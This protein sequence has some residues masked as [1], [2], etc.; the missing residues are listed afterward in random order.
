MAIPLSA[1]G[2]DDT[3]EQ[4]VLIH[5]QAALDIGRDGHVT[6]VEFVDKLKVPDAIRQRTR[7]VAGTWAFAPPVK[8]GRAVT[9]RTYADVEACLIPGKDGLDFSIAFS[10]NGPAQF[11]VPPRKPMSLSMPL[12]DLQEQ[13]IKQIEGKVVYVVD[14]GGHAQVETATLN[15][16]ALQQRYG[17]LWK[18]DQREMLRNYRYLPEMVDG[19]AIATRME[20]ELMVGERPP[21]ASLE[22]MRQAS[23]DQSDACRAVRGEDHKRVAI[24]SPFRHVG[25]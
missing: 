15:D 25:G 5:M 22:A 6:G 4:P 24:D 14:A 7:D 17:S 21:T 10:G 8:D 18:R 12:E 13:G 1:L 20:T 3:G 2:A 11:V 19:V 9:G 16:A 23:A